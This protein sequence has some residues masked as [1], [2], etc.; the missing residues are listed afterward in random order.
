MGFPKALMRIEGYS[1]ALFLSRTFQSAG[2]NHVY[3]TL[4]NHFLEGHELVTHLKKL[5]VSVLAN[6]YLEQGYAGS[7]M[8]VVAALPP[9]CQGLFITPIDSYPVKSLI[10]TMR[11]LAQ[12]HGSKPLIIIPQCYVQDGHPVYLSKHF[13]K[14]LRSCHLFSGLNR[15]IA[16]YHH[17]VLRLASFESRVLANLNDQKALFPYSH[18]QLIPSSPL[19]KLFSRD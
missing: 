14:A 15:L 10:I 6:R 9:S 13:F 2:L 8:S 19:F 3:I 4:P 12:A 7:I 17:K 18:S 5:S 11:N 1:A 16:F